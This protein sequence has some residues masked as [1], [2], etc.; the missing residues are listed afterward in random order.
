M[1][2]LFSILICSSMASFGE[3]RLANPKT[4]IGLCDASAGVAV[5]SD[6]FVVADD[7]S[8]LLRTYSISKPGAPVQTVNLDRFLKVEKKSPE[9]DIEGAAQMGDSVFWIT[10]HGQ[11]KNGKERKSR[12]R[13]FT[14]RANSAG[15]LVPDGIP[16]TRLVSDLES[17]PNLEAYRFK[18]AAK[19]APKDKDALNIEGLA[20]G[21]NESLL[22][23]FRNPIPQ[24][25]A[26]IIPLLNAKM[27]VTETGARARFGEPI[28]IDLGGQ[29]IRAIMGEPGQYYIVGGG[30]DSGERSTL[31]TWDGK[32]APARIWQAIDSSVTIEAVFEIP[33][34]QGGSRMMAL[35]DD[36]TR[37]V[38]GGECKELPPEQRVFR[39]FDL[40]LPAN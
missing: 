12:E 23:G 1:R 4:Y 37:N 39:A 25:K 22:I 24:G 17:D 20:V 13:I 29:G 5:T 8:N 34:G 14:T 10:S 32:S 36:G 16:Y 2:V 11:N 6:L 26:L 28:E 3:A 33:D 35:S 15:E 38:G 18:A 21:P 40:V 19:R 27:V 31:W 9:A 7:E 30:Y